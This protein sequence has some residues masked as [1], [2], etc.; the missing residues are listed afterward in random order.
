[1]RDSDKGPVFTEVVLEIFKLGGLLVNE[2][3]QMADEFGITSARWK[4]MGAISLAGKPQTVPQIARA[5]GLTRQ[6]VQRLVDA[7]YNDGFL[8]FQTNPDHKRARLI[9]LSQRG[10]KSYAQLDK[11]QIE[12]AKKCSAKLSKKE[13][14]TTLSVLRKVSEYLSLQG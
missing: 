1:M 14:D 13:L 12:W 4:I 11:K 8:E 7:M 5:M 6:A 2:G 9:M 3:D 10:V